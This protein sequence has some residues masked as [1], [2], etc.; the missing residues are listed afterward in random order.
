MGNYISNIGTHVYV[1]GSADAIRLYKEAFN[2]E[3]KGEPITDK[4]GDIY[5]HML[6]RD[7]EIFIY[8]YED[9][10][11]PPELVKKYSDDSKPI[12]LFSV[13]F[14]NE[15]DI[16]KAFRILSENGNPCAGLKVESW[17]ILSCEVI[18][19]FGVFWYL[20]IPKD[21]NAPYVHG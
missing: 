1:K 13:V 14:E 9:K 10:F 11:L 12:M 7:G 2:L 21:K 6:T 19:K 15:D 5:H 16:R 17:T 4:D 3:D 8:V 18:D 20:W